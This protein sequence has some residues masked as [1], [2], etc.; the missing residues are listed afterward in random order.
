MIELID[1]HLNGSRRLSNSRL[2]HLTISQTGETSFEVFITAPHFTGDGTTLHNTAHELLVLLSNPD[3]LGSNLEAALKT[4]TTLPPSI[5][6]S[7]GYTTTRLKGAAHKV[8]YQLDKRKQLGGHCLPRKKGLRRTI[9]REDSLDE[10]QTRSLLARCKEKGVSISNLM[11][12]I[13]ACA[14]TRVNN[15]DGKLPMW[16]E[17]LNRLIVE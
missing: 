6:E 8:I 5:D 10:S 15:L 4:P 17:I 2:S 7:L 1:R 13:V 16:V 9:L 14:W 12:A 11:F 3:S